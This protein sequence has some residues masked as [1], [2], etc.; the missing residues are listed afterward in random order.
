MFYWI[1]EV[2][3]N[4]HDDVEGVIFD[5]SRD[6]DFFDTRLEIRV[7]FLWGSKFPAG[8]EDDVDAEV[9]PRDIRKVS[10]R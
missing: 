10:V 1:I 9:R 8:F 7:E 4:A 5:G 6:D 2:V 3:I